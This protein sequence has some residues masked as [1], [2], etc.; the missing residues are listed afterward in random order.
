MS[1]LGRIRDIRFRYVKDFFNGDEIE[2]IQ[3]LEITG[4]RHTSSAW[5]GRDAPP[6]GS[7]ARVRLTIRG[8]RYQLS[9][10]LKL[11]SAR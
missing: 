9:R 8:S 7:Q 2:D 5:E 4:V 3:R 1:G 11:R 10:L 6:R